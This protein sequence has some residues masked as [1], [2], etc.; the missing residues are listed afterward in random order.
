[1]FEVTTLIVLIL[2]IC[3]SKENTQKILIG[4]LIGDGGMS[5]S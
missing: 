1:M 3:K 2:R 5:L 4:L